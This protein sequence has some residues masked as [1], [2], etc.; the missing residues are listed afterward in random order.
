MSELKVIYSPKGPS[1]NRSEGR[2]IIHFYPVCSP[3]STVLVSVSGETTLKE[4][5]KTMKSFN[6][7]L[8]Q[9]V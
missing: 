1:E 8:G 3:C 6:E 4:T 9:C 5:A 2:V 7:Q